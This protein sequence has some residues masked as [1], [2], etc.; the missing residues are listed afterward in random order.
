MYVSFVFI[1]FGSYVY[2]Q[3]LVKKKVKQSHDRP[4][5]AHRVPGG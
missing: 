2:L 3:N 1:K 5:Q 4:G